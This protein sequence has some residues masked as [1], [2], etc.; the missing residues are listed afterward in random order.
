MQNICY[1]MYEE[2][3]TTKK[4]EIKK[5]RKRKGKELPNIQV[6]REHDY[7]KE[8]KKE[9]KMNKRNCRIFRY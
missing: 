5:K 3:M 9:K 8:S 6:L 2:R 1:V 4:E 7:Q